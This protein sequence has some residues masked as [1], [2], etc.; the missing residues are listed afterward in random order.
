MQKSIRKWLKHMRKDPEQTLI[1]IGEAAQLLGVSTETMRRW[2]NTGNLKA[3]R[4][5]TNGKR[6]YNRLDLERFMKGKK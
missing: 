3:I 4:L 5:A 1:D 6:M 2:D